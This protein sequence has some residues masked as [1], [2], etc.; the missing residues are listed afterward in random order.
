M[1][2]A[3]I[4]AVGLAVIAGLYFRTNVSRVLLFWAAFESE[5]L[6]KT[7]RHRASR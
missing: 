4:F 3:L 7:L 1:G 5:L 2:G 6:T